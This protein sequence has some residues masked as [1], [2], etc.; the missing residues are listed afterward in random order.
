MNNRLYIGARDSGKT[1]SLFQDIYAAH[2]ARRPVVVVDSATDHKD[3]SL[4][5]RL[6]REFTDC[7]VAVEFPR[8]DGAPENRLA[9]ILAEAETGKVVVIDV[10]YYLEEGHRLA[11]PWE[12][13]VTRVRYQVEAGEV[14]R[15]IQRLMVEGGLC[16]V[17]VALDEIEFTKTIMACAVVIAEYGG[18]VHAALHPPA[19]D[20]EFVG[21][22]KNVVL[23]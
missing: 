1:S 2:I 5:H 10:S 21:D 3:R 12:K 15:T 16:G 19:V 11:D 7:C 13:A 9:Q 18:E 14:L 6:L 23:S 20:R 4:Y 17:F 8:S 22:F